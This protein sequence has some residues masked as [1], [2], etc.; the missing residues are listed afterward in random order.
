MTAYFRQPSPDHRFYRQQREPLDKGSRLWEKSFLCRALVKVVKKGKWASSE[1]EQLRALWSGTNEEEHCTPRTRLAN[2]SQSGQLILNGSPIEPSVL[3]NLT[4]GPPLKLPGLVPNLP[5]IQHCYNRNTHSSTGRS[6]FS[7]CYGFQP[8]APMDLVADGSDD[9]C[10]LNP[11]SAAAHLLS[12]R[13]AAEQLRAV[14]FLE[15]GGT[16]GR[17]LIL[18]R[19]RR[20]NRSKGT[21]ET[22]PII[23]SRWEI[24]CG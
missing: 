13:E 8:K 3:E 14:S 24:D 10:V 15:N 21:T 9:G 20:G 22:E 7:V 17:L 19:K 11:V 6:A 23:S 4:S 2:Q 1:E 12:P 18:W 5:F 16:M